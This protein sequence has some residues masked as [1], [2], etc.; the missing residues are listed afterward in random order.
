[1]SNNDFTAAKGNNKKPKALRLSPLTITLPP[2]AGHHSG[3]KTSAMH[4]AISGNIGSGKTTL[5][6]LLANHYGWEA[7]LEPV[8]DTPYH[9][10]YYTDKPRR[11]F[12]LEVYY[13]KE[14]FREA[15]SIAASEA[16][17]V[18]DRTVWESMAVFAENNMRMGN[19]AWRDYQTLT[20]L[21][22]LM[23]P[24]LSLPDLTIYLRADIAHL[25]RNIQR[26]GR[27]YE[28]AISIEYLQ[29]LN[30]LYD[31]F[32]L[33]LFPGRVLTVDVNGTDFENNPRDLN[34]IFEKT[35]PLVR[36]L[37]PL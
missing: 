2:S 18:Q 15:L 26:R 21:F 34:L 29:G 11:A 30:A 7:R 35:D 23:R 27:D 20:S 19:L 14:R 16:S 24:Q 12:H 25:V 22:D 3:A 32:M 5:T 17:V 13:L 1:M 9:L 31:R 28:Q 37:F 36:G 10:A 4:I 8:T 6:R 33:E